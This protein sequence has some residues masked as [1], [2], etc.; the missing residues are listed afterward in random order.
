M[1]IAYFDCGSGISGDMLVG[2]LVDAGVSLADLNAGIASL[3]LPG[4]KFAARSVHKCGFRATQVT[5][6]HKPDNKHRDLRQILKLIE[7]SLLTPDQQELAARIFHRLG[8]AEA[9]V[10]GIPL[11]Q[12]HF[13]E[14]GAV[15][16]IAD[17]C[18]AAIA[19]DLLNIDRVVASAIPTG[20][21]RV[22][23]AHGDVT[24]PAPATIELL[25]GAPIAP[26]EVEREL[27]TPTGAAVLATVVNDY[28]ALPAMTVEHIGYGAGQ[29]DLSTQPNVLR[30][31]IGQGAAPGDDLLEQDVVWVLETNLDNLTGE[32]IGHACQ[33]LL[34]EGALDVY[35]TAIQ[36][37]KGRPGT[38]IS[39]LAAPSDADRLE[40]TLFRE[41]HT[42]G[43]RRRLMARHKLPRQPLE[44][45]TPWGA[46]EGKL[47]FVPGE[48]FAFNPEY[49]QCKKLARDNRIPLK[50][51]YQHA[52]WG[53]GDKDIE[54]EG[55][56]EHDHDCSRD[57][58]HG[59]H[60]HEHDHGHS[61][62]HGGHSHD[63]DHGGHSHDHD[64]GHSHD[65]DHGGHSHDHD[66]GPD[67]HH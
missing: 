49:E 44:V 30:V 28:G 29:A 63:H 17:I 59:G 64:H 12:V 16:S 67:H 15:D 19:L 9:K 60:H 2:A 14:V 13:H 50:D 26:S 48:S 55:E 62:D 66:H 4:V 32:I 5:V 40:R 41:T 38:L 24:I 7:G 8:E 33:R 3:G 20:K 25:K 18:G 58:D 61:H 57:H 52:F 23:I 34:D 36:M 6:E 56:H 11:E 54:V 46:V 35:T 47:A 43:V 65:H 1:R 27:T 31:L 37:K 45:E 21:G 39:V 42:L 53:F 51:V 10:H 22:K